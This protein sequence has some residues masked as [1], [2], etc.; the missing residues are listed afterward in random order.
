MTVIAR[1][2]NIPHTEWIDLKG[3]GVLVE[4]AIL[5]EDANGN[6]HYIEIPNLDDIDKRRL[7]SIL[8][9]RNVNNFELWDLMSQVTLNNGVNSLA[10]FH[11]LVRVITSQG[12][13][14]N[15][16]DGHIGI[17]KVSIGDKPGEVKIDK[18]DDE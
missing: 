10:Y 7:V 17:G 18:N 16:R 2:G 8:N 15:P 13:I 12:V 14:M 11:Q 5:K 6:K 9:N 1:K 4:C 3:N